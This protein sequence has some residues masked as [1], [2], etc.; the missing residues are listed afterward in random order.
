MTVS[1]VMKTR[2]LVPGTT[3]SIRM[4][5][6]LVTSSSFQHDNNSNMFHLS[7]KYE[8]TYMIVLDTSK[9][10]PERKITL[11]VCAFSTGFSC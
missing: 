7:R 10:D 9:D 2:L 5:G 6:W 8:V 4:L 3:L 1:L 11:T